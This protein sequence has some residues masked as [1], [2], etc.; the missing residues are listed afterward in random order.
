MRGIKKKQCISIIKRYLDLFELK[1]DFLN[2]SISNLSSGEKKKFSLIRCMAHDP[3][4]LIL[5]N[6]RIFRF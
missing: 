3:Y 4:L 6:Q 5:M 2:H 1:K